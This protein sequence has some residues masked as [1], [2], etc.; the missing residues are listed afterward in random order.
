MWIRN[1]KQIRPLFR[2][3]AQPFRRYATAV[4][5]H[6]RAEGAGFIASFKIRSIVWCRYI[7]LC[8]NLFPIAKR[9]I[10]ARAERVVARN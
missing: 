2:F 8:A 9:L 5:A 4:F 3:L 10:F 6:P 1:K 7:N